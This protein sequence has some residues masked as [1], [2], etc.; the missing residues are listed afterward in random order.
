MIYTPGGLPIFSKCFGGFCQANAT[1]DVLLSGFL[2]A[3]ET[4]PAMVGGEGLKAV[5][6]GTTKFVFRKTTPS[7]VSIAIGL[8][9]KADQQEAIDVFEAVQSLIEV[10]YNETNWDVINTTQYEAFKKDLFENALDPAL[11]NYGG[12]EDQCPMGEQCAMHTMPISE[13][14]QP[15]WTRIRSIYDQVRAMM[16]REMMPKA[17]DKQSVWERIR[18]KL[19]R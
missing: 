7:G 11:H 1:D 16:Q 2:S 19:R 10:K 8:S 18:G 13:E 4:F 9:E 14:K 15:I 17:A 5:E 6:M 12:F 3:L